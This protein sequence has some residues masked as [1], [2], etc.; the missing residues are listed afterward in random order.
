M[1][2]CEWWEQSRYGA[3]S[4]PKSAFALEKLKPEEVYRRRKEIHSVDQTQDPRK[5]GVDREREM[6]AAAEEI[7]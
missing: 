7:N 3:N 2:A 5:G 1:A 4:I 6:E